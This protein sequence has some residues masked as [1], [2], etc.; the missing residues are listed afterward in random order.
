MKLDISEAVS[1]GILKPATELRVSKEIEGDFN[2]GLMYGD[3]DEV[4]TRGHLS[5]SANVITEAR[6]KKI[7][8]RAEFSEYLL[9]PTKFKFPATVRILGYV[10]CFVKKARK[11]RQFLGEL[12]REAKLWFSVFS[13]DLS[14]VKI[15]TVKVMTSH[16][17]KLGT[18]NQTVV[19]GHFAVKKLMLN[20][21]E[22][23]QCIL[24][25]SCLH[26]SLVYLFRKGTME[27]KHFVN[28]KT[29]SRIA[30]EVDGILLSKGRLMDGMNF[31][32]TG[33]LGDLNIGSLG[34]KINTP[35]LERHSPLSYCIAQY[36]HWSVGRHRG[37]ETTHRLSFEHVSIIQ[38]MTLYRDI[39]EQCIR[40][41][42][43]RKRLLEVPMEHV[44]KE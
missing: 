2:D 15:T 13:C 12:L 38:G 30:Y 43:K 26:L 34:I 35:V 14:D 17:Q 22:V 4:L 41:H 19:L 9:L 23:R 33:E 31:I 36:V 18:T 27:V 21:T 1:R 42:M 25:D 24:N 44:A 10:L 37:I 29:I 5:T 6:V 3:R 40:Y 11:G 20:S 8:E 28:K 7:Q 39:A 32:E 16:N